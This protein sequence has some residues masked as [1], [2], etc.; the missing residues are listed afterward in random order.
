L[1]KIKEG[2]LSVKTLE[3][4]Q[5]YIFIQRQDKPGFYEMNGKL[6]NQN[7]YQEFCKK[8]K[9]KNNN[10]II[11]NEGKTYEDTIITMY[12]SPDCEPINEEIKTWVSSLTLK[13]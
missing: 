11:W 1:Q 2:K 13:I 5:T 8:I 4:P 9:D 7:E 3:P 6:F 12:T 10:S